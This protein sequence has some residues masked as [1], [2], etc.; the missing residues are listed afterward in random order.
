M[1]SGPWQKPPRQPRPEA[2]TF[3]SFIWP[4]LGQW[5]AGRP[6]AAALQ[7][8]PVLLA[9]I[10][11]AVFVGGD[12]QRLAILL[13]DPATAVAIIVL[14]LLT[15]ALRL[16]S[17]VHAQA[18]ASRR[19]AFR[20]SRPAVFTVL[21]MVA[22]VVHL[23]AASIAMDFY[24]AGTKIFVDDPVTGGVTP[25]PAPGSS[26]APQPTAPPV[27]EQPGRINVLLTG[28]DSSE[29]RNHALTDTLI[30]VSID[31]ATKDVAMVSFPRDIARFPLW[32]GRQFTGKINSLM[33][34]AAQRPNEFPDGGLGTVTREL[35]FLLG[36]PIDYY[37]AINL[38]GFEKLI[39]EVGGVRIVN[40][41]AIA[42]PAYGGWKD[43]H[44][45]FFLSAGPH[46]L[47]GPNALAYVRS[48]K[49]AGDNDFTRA[50][51]Q[52]QLLVALR[53]KLTD[54]AMLPRLSG[55]LNA[56]SATLTTNFPSGRL[57]ELL[58]LGTGIK[59]DEIRRFVLGP[60]YA[61]HPPTN[62]T[63]GTYI[64][65]LDFERVAKLSV[66]LFGN[67]SRY[68]QLGAG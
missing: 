23:T 30:V 49:G 64:L 45:G 28:I 37:A 54:P 4:G 58:D 15:G 43:G 59:D 42:D 40:D 20:G 36:V 50:R 25:S 31:R 57:S 66:Q 7:A 61:I 8:I 60:P 56:A 10:A 38:D 22:I 35:G 5:Y 65:S 55:V 29:I 39:D 12:L 17:M 14:I 19:E 9:L 48:R 67:D 2:A 1:T 51:R 21:A 32:D 11:V 46:T 34:Y 27:E 53:Q 33:T 16:G 63:G 13:F 6:K 24:T 3:L 62:T 52:Q 18:I 44:I 26:P 47:D 41:K 68:A